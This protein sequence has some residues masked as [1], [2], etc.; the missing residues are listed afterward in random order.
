MPRALLLVVALMACVAVCAEEP[1]YQLV[2][3]SFTNQAN[4]ARWAR[5]VADELH[6]TI[7]VQPITIGSAATYRVVTEPLSGTDLRQ[8]MANARSRSIE[9]WRLAAPVLA[10]VESAQQAES[11]GDAT[12]LPGETGELPPAPVAAQPESHPQPASEPAEVDFDLGL[13]Q[14]TFFESGLD[15][16]SESDPSVSGELRF[17]KRWLDGTY[18]FALTGFGRYDAQDDRRTHADLREAYL[19][20]V[21]DSW[22]LYVGSRQVFWGVTEFEHLVDIINQTDQ[23][24]DIEGEVK[25]G[26][27]MVNLSLVRDWGIVDFFVMPYFRER[28]YPAVCAI[29]FRST[30]TT[31]STIRETNSITSTGRYA[32]RRIS[33]RSSS[34]CTSSRAPAG[35]RC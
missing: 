5:K 23:V 30:S 34:G 21:G 32:G 18:N 7:N 14:R 26:Q 15:G 25:L 2:L 13:Q 20:W 11:V 6:L 22:D 1:A 9:F 33:G 12:A 19:S 17:T 10:P 4:A 3:G 24:E 31:R 28:T 16:Q 8:A 35:R 29:R 27:P